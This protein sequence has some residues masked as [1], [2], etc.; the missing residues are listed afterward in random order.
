MSARLDKPGR[1]IRNFR[2]I[3]HP[4]HRRQGLGS[5]V[6]K[7]V[8]G[9]DPD[10]DTTLQ[11]AC[12]RSWE[13]GTA[14]L[15]HR[16]FEAT[17]QETWMVFRGAAPA[18]DLAPDLAL[19]DWDG[20]P[21]LAAAWQRLTEEAYGDTPDS[22]EITDEDLRLLPTEPGF[23]L[24]FLERG[25][26]VLGLCHVNEYSQRLYVNSLAVTPDHRGRGHGRRLLLDMLERTQGDGVEELRL[27]VRSEN[28]PALRLYEATGFETEDVSRK[29][30]KR[31]A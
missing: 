6:L 18:P 17:R 20:S 2:I 28:T 4:S 7:H 9:Q 14:F 23:R 26:E 30:C 25:D 19:R 16:G 12:L 3:V 8:E 15:R 27:S 11:A 31:L 13:A 24:R 22:V 21:G 10:G 29:W 5:R 1:D